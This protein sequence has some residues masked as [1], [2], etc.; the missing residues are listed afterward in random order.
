MRAAFLRVDRRGLLGT[1][2]R[3]F[4]RVLI[5]R[6]ISLSDCKETLGREPVSRNV[7]WIRVNTLRDGILRLEKRPLVFFYS[8]TCIAIAKSIHKMHVTIFH[9]GNTKGIISS[10]YNWH[11]NHSQSCG[12]LHYISP[13][14]KYENMCSSEAKR[15]MNCRHMTPHSSSEMDKIVSWQVQ[16][17]DS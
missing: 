8:S 10:P 11:T 1:I 3:F 5:V 9:V 17:V 2:S 12:K 16:C 14:S 4:P 7:C 6:T 13:W 15:E